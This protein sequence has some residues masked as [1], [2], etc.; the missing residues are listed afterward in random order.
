M[1]KKYI[2]ELTED[3]RFALQEATL[4]SRRNKTLDSLLSAGLATP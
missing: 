3:E 4:K 1:K 2:V